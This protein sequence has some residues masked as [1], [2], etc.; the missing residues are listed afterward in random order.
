MLVDLHYRSFLA[1]NHWAK[2]I[3]AGNGHP[4]WRSGFHDWF[5]VLCEKY[6]IIFYDRELGKEP[7]IAAGRVILLFL[8]V[9]AKGEMFHFLLEQVHLSSVSGESSLGAVP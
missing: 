2:T 7:Y 8:N 6:L 3:R 1:S 9:D 5:I 4:G